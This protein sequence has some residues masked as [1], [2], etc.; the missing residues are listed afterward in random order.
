M[1]DPNI[2]LRLCL[3][4]G[5]DLTGDLARA[6]IRFS[7]G[8]YD[9]SFEGYQISVTPVSEGDVPFELG[10]GTVRV[11]AIYDINIWVPILKDTNKGRGVAKDHKWKM[12]EKVKSIL[13]ANLTGLTGLRYVV[14][15][16]SGRSLDEL[17]CTP[18]I[19]RYGLTVSVIYDI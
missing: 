13:K 15:D 3:Y 2:T 4:N 9:S 11:F 10:Y 16:Q 12:V 18:P 19:L 1:Q 14:L 6:N 5:W 17:N 7:T 8:W